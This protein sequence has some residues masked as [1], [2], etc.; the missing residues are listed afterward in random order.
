DFSKDDSASITKLVGGRESFSA[1]TPRIL[2]G[3]ARNA[4]L[5]SKKSRTILTAVVKSMITPLELADRTFLVTGAS[6]GIGREAAI[7]LSQLG[8]RVILTARDE[9]RLQ[10]TRALL[11]SATHA[12]E[13]FELANTAAIEPWLAGVVQRHGKL[14]GIAHCGGI[15]QTLPI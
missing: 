10:A 6:S 3:A 8:A 2:T 15:Q 9:Q 1:E 13:P 14:S 11:E 12:I 5:S 4:G 7:V